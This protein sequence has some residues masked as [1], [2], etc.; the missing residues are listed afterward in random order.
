MIRFDEIF[1]PL[2]PE[3]KRRIK[4]KNQQEGCAI[5]TCIFLFLGGLVALGYWLGHNF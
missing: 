1:R 3:E 4:R 5:L 2:T